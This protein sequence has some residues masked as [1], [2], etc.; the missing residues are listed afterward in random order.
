[1]ISRPRQPGRDPSVPEE[2]EREV[3]F[4]LT[5]AM[6]L[7]I[8]GAVFVAGVA[9]LPPAYA[10]LKGPRQFTVLGVSGD[11]DAGLS[12]VAGGFAI[13][14][15][16]LGYAVA[17]VRDLIGDR[18]AVRAVGEEADEPVAAAPAVVRRGAPA[19]AGGDGFGAERLRIA[20]D[21]SA[22][23]FT[24][25]G[26]LVTVGPAGTRL[27][28]VPCGR[29][30]LHLPDLR[31]LVALS[32]DGRRSA[33]VH[34]SFGIVMR[35]IPDDEDSERPIVHRS[36]VWRSG[37]GGVSALAFSP[38]GLRLATAGDPDTR[39]WSVADGEELLRIAT[40]ATEFYGLR[41]DFSPDGRYLATTATDRSV[42]VWDAC[43]GRRLQRLDHRPH[44]YGRVATA[45]AFSPDSRLLAT[46]C[47]DG[48]AWIWDLSRGSAM[49]HLAP[50]HGRAPNFD[51]RT[52]AWGPDGT[53]LAVPCNDGTV[54][55]CDT[56]S[57]AEILRVRHS[58][59]Q[60]RPRR[61]RWSGVDA[62][63][64]VSGGPR[65]V[66]VSPDGTLLAAGGGRGDVRVWGLA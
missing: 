13:G 61:T 2:F 50:G 24:A 16:L 45:V 5:I 7:N 57:G 27:W 9:M 51:P 46:L 14:L 28:E 12:A 3:P 37:A 1:M 42:I 44:R 31:G 41:I 56:R 21:A 20:E 64:G 23:T 30:L 17:L 33:T 63:V 53:R 36:S 47:A 22:V 54:R 4:I 32:P 60:A 19:A 26:E 8:V 48:S 38:D 25:R 29:E 39:V 18:P 40:G 49:L 15:L 62:V 66:A 34:G 11:A 55:V 58:D 52:L 43:D 10:L 35:S 59:P 6:W 65:A